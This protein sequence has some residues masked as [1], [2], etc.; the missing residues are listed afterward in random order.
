M[1]NFLDFNVPPTA[2]LG[3]AFRILL[4]HTE[5]ERETE[6]DRQTERER[7]T[8]RQTERDRHRERERETEGLK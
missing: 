6:T 5:R 2:A 4:H 8:D 3:Q 7:E 1:V